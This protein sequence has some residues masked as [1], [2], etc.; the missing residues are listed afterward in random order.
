MEHRLNYFNYSCQ[1][2]AVY[3]A[4]L[5][6]LTLLSTGSAALNYL[7]LVVIST[8]DDLTHLFSRERERE[9]MIKFIYQAVGKDN[10]W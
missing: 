5:L 7:L 9:N 1:D 4:P 6:A 8:S 10:S 3:E 2:I